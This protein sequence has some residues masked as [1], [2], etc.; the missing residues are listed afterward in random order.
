MQANMR[1]YA[2]FGHLISPKI[3]KPSSLFEL[4][5]AAFGETWAKRSPKFRRVYCF[6]YNMRSVKQFLDVEPSKFTR[7]KNSVFDISGEKSKI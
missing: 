3:D 6:T 4:S 7:K 2:T 5:F 1:Q